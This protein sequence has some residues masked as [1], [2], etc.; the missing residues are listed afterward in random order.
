MSA[1]VFDQALL[2][3]REHDIERVF[4]RLVSEHEIANP[5]LLKYFI[6]SANYIKT[7]S[8]FIK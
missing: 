8:H 4:K 7:L 3:L 2:V 5:D 1:T 6:L